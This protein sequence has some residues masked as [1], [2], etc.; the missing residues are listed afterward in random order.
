MQY[1]PILICDS[2]ISNYVRI[3][4]TRRLCCPAFEV[5]MVDFQDR[6]RI[7]ATSHHARCSI[8]VR[9]RLIIRRLG[10]GPGRL[11][12][13]AE[14]KRHLGRQYR[15][16]QVYW[17]HRSQS[18][19]DAI[20]GAPI[21]HLSLIVDGMGQAKHAYPKSESL[22]SKEFASWSRPRLAATTILA[23]GHAVVVGLS[24][25]NVPTSGSRTM[26]LVSYMMTKTLSYIHWPNVFLHLEADNCC[27]E[28]KHQTSLRMMGTMIALHRLRGCEFSYLSTGHSH[29][30][31]DAYFSLASSWLERHKE[32]WSINDFQKC[33]TAMLANKQVR[34]NEPK[35][36]VVVFDRFRDWKP[37]FII[38]IL[39]VKLMRV[40]S[41]YITNAV[42]LPLSWGQWRL[43]LAAKSMR[44]PASNLGARA[45]QEI[46]FWR[47]S[48]ASS[49][50]GH[51]GARCASCV[52][53]GALERYRT[54]QWIL[55]PW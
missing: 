7:R 32:L 39:L 11:A 9:H 24:P 20:S 4:V 15:D 13:I 38:G 10:Q 35:R 28:L 23:H 2:L 53:T 49:P 19:S 5:W 3:C 8:C 52:Q 42:T 17:G 16:R 50:E 27:K 47:A 55:H 36:D 30:D 1:C 26:E 22:G 51:R 21:R 18:R 46:A 43:H 25:D 45:A 37:D 54:K 40:I 29:E 41:T 44:Y 34:V 48:G 6:L 33:L 12:Q 14:Y 31:I